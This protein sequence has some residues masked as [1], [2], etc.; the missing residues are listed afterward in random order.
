VLFGDPIILASR[1]ST[2]FRHR[3]PLSRTALSSY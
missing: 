2:R 1:S 3:S